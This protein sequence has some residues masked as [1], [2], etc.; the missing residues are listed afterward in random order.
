MQLSRQLALSAKRQGGPWI[1]RPFD[2]AGRGS[3][4]DDGLG[5]I[6]GES[7]LE[8][9]ARH[10]PGVEAAGDGELQLD[11]RQVRLKGQRPLKGGD[12][13]LVILDPDRDQGAVGS[14]RDVVRRRARRVQHRPLAGALSLRRMRPALG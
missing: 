3:S 9:E 5:R 14:R 13:G 2:G 6:G 12:G 11:P 10:L 7:L 1:E 4:G 8:V